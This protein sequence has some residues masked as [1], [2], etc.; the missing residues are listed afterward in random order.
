MRLFTKRLIAV[1]TALSMAQMASVSF[2]QETLITTGQIAAT[3]SSA[4]GS[5]QARIAALLDRPEL[6]AK[7]LERGVDI[8]EA[9]MRVAALS[10]DEARVLAERIDTLPAG[11]VD[12]LGALLV[13]FIVLLIT[14]ILGY[15]KVFSFTRPMK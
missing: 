6:Q 11:G 14:D 12:V 7:L 8:D 10:D 13:V 1:V 15:T 3:Q 9:R 4:P 5:H 2:A